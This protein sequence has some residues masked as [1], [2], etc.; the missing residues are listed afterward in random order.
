MDKNDCDE[1][2]DNDSIMDAKDEPELDEKFHDALFVDEEVDIKP[3]KMD[4]VQVKLN[5]AKEI[6]SK[7]N[8]KVNDVEKTIKKVDKT[9]LTIFSQNS[10]KIC[11]YF[12]KNCY[13]GGHALKKKIANLP[14]SIGPGPISLILQ[15]AITMFVN[16]N[17]FPWI[18]LKKIKKIQKM[19]FNGPGG[20][21]MRV[22]T[23]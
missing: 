5:S 18:A 15:E 12:N 16:L 11:I 17:L 3:G 21:E 6:D 7:K 20:I 14:E 10:N 19:L 8:K 9:S 2:N 23:K 1:E 13:P 4:T 22:S